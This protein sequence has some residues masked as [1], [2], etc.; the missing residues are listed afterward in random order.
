MDGKIA[1]IPRR[2]LKWLGLVK[3]GSLK[4]KLRH[5]STAFA[6]ASLYQRF[7]F[8]LVAGRL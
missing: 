4:R 2:N 5:I 1:E 7:V 6:I 3:A 8:G